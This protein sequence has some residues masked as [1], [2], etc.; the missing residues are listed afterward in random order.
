MK[1]VNDTHLKFNQHL[2]ED[3]VFSS[4]LYCKHLLENKDTS[5]D[6][7]LTDFINFFFDGNKFDA[8]NRLKQLF[9]HYKFEYFKNRLN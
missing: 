3:D 6:E 8:L 2:S 1:R 7:E 9:M 5:S 4:M